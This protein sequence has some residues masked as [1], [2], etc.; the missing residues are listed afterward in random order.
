MLQA[1]EF[2]SI[3]LLGKRSQLGPINLKLPVF[4]F[5]HRHTGLSPVS[6]CQNVQRG[7]ERDIREEAERAGF[8]QA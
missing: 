7:E 5:R 3:A 8:G 2:Q 4:Y 1:N 6:C